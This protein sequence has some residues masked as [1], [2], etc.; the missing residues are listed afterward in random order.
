MKQIFY[1]DTYLFL[2]I[3]TTMSSSGMLRADDNVDD[4]EE[5]KALFWRH[6]ISQIVIHPI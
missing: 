1:T 6:I 4:D 5:H 2:F 3:N